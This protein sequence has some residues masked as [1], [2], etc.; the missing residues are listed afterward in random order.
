MSYFLGID[1]GT[2][3]TAAA[4]VRGGVAEMAELGT[5]SVVAPSVV[6]ARPDGTRL[7]GEAAERRSTQE[8]MHVAREFKRRL[9]D[10]AP[11]LLGGVPYSAEQLTSILLAWVIEQVARVEGGPPARIALT[12][13][14]NWGQFKLDVLGQAARLAGLGDDVVTLT[15]PTAAAIA[16]AAAERIPDDARVAVYDLG[17]GTFDATVLQR[18]GD[19]FVEIGQP[20]GIDRLGGIDVDQAVLAH[21]SESVGAPLDELDPDE[22]AV[23]AQLARLR[24]DCVDAKESLSADVDVTIPVQI[25]ATAG[26]VRLTRGE[27]ETMVRPT[28]EYTVDGLR[29][30]IASAGLTPED[31]HA[32]LLAGGSSRIPLIAQLV[33]GGIGRPIAVDLHPKHAVA[34]GAALAAARAGAAPSSAPAAVPPTAPPVAPSPPAAPPRAPSSVD[35]GPAWLDSDETFTHHAPPA[36]PEYGAPEPAFAPPASTPPPQPVADAPT[37]V[38]PHQPAPADPVAAAGPAP[39]PAAPSRPADEGPA[40]TVPLDEHRSE[41]EV[42]R[43]R[44]STVLTAVV[45][46]VAVVIIGAVAVV[47]LMDDNTPGG[48]ADGS[49]TTTAPAEAVEGE[50][51]TVDQYLASDELRLVVDDFA[52]DENQWQN[53]VAADPENART[54]CGT[55]LTLVQ[56]DYGDLDADGVPSDLTAAADA[57]PDPLLRGLML[58][59]FRARARSWQECADGAARE[60]VQASEAEAVAAKQEFNGRL[61]DLQTGSP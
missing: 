54:Y 11:V 25:G 46:A 41:G 43:R 22:P 14:A 55:L 50:E 8:P 23:A 30:A 48:A 47:R 10:S 5:R 18:T 61:S 45:A 51:L 36:A 31:I 59:W 53:D 33:G 32:V 20:E 26:E 9:G 44:S 56:E 35:P 17:G 13:P 27:L 24:R 58:D 57:A 4:V 12:H 1:L 52:S 7:V 38:W 60:V 34:R 2:T 28:L 15:E 16:Y 39:T 29:R 40:Y 37:E 21:V 42:D 6:L 49:T 3:Y 19:S